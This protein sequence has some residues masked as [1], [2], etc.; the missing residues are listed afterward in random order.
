MT[1]ALFPVISTN[2]KTR[3]LFEL[4]HTEAKAKYQDDGKMLICICL[5]GLR[6]ARD[7]WRNPACRGSAERRERDDKINDCC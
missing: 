2:L 4:F 5:E 3:E 7:V 1:P 6:T